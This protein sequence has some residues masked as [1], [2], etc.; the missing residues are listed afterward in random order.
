MFLFES[1]DVEVYTM[2]LKLVMYMRENG[3]HSKLCNF[4]Q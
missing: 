2:K 1:N 4:Q 3:F